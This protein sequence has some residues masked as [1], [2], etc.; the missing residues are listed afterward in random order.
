LVWAGQPDPQDTRVEVRAVD[1]IQEALGALLDGLRRVAPNGI[2]S[3]ELRAKL[4]P[5]NTEDG[6]DGLRGALEALTN[7][8]QPSAR[9]I[10]KALPR[11]VNRPVDGFV[12][13]SA[14]D[15]H[16]KIWAWGVRPAHPADPQT[17]RDHSNAS[18]AKTPDSR[19]E[20][21]HDKAANANGTPASAGFAESH[22]QDRAKSYAV[23]VKRIE[24]ERPRITVEVMHRGGH[25]T[26]PTAMP[27]TIPAIDPGPASA[28]ETAHAGQTNV[29][30]KTDAT[31]VGSSAPRDVAVGDIVDHHTFGMCEVLELD[32]T[33]VNGV[34]CD[35][36]KVRVHK[37]GST[38]TIVV[39]PQHAL[40]HA[41]VVDG[42]HLYELALKTQTNGVSVAAAE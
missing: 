27:G 3:A 34:N 5:R 12:L 10:G 36:L 38:K 39:T 9:K 32:A 6:F 1:T 20:T 18:S 41:G 17:E 8:D 29:E 11:Y 40:E 7:A 23:S 14:W 4:W 16:K 28:P 37:N 33:V 2:T 22:A 35:R 30:Q 19:T 31:I 26:S 21:P 24:Q 13:H 15:S 25:L 42:K